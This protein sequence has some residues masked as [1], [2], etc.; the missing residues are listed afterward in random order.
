MQEFRFSNDHGLTQTKRVILTLSTLG[1]ISMIAL[2][3]SA[4]PDIRRY[5]RMRAM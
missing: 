1:M 4:W 5:M 3:V 2:M